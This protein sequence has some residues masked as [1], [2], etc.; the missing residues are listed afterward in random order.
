M[1]QYNNKGLSIKHVRIQGGG[2]VRCGHLRTRGSVFTIMC[3]RLLWT[4]SN[5]CVVVL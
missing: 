4:A 3:G 5:L 2:V 1:A